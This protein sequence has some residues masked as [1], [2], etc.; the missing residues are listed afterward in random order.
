MK[1][2]PNCHFSQ[3]GVETSE[4]QLI[5]QQGLLAS[6]IDHHA[7]FDELGGSVWNN[8]LEADT[9]SSVIFQN[10]LQRSCAVATIGPIELP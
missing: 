8:W 7:S 10:N 1:V 5:P 2:A 4:S 9:H 6:R 3:F